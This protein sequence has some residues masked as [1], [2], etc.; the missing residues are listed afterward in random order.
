MS[1]QLSLLDAQSS[2]S[3][4]DDPPA[5]EAPFPRFT[6]P[7]RAPRRLLLLFGDQLDNRYLNAAGLDPKLDA[8][9]MMEV[10]EEAC[11]VPSHKARTTLFLS[12]MRHFA[13]RLV[14]D[15]APLI[16]RRLDETGPGGSFARELLCL[17]KCWKGEPESLV[18]VRPGEWRVLRDVEAVCE[19]LGWTF[20]MIEDDHFLSTPAQFSRWAKGRKQLVMEYFY[21]DLRR[22]LDVLMT[23]EKK[24]E[25]GQWNFDKDNRKPLKR[26][27]PPIPPPLRFPPDG[28]TRKVMA[29]VEQTFPDAPGRLSSFAWP[30][31][32][33]QVLTALQDFVDNRLPYFGDYQDAMKT[34]EPWLFHSLL[35]PAMNLKLLDP[36]EAVEAAVAAY[37]AGSAPLNAVEGFVRQIVGWREFIR[38]VYWHEGPGYSER[39]SLEATGD[40]PPMYWH[41]ETEMSC[42][43]DALDQVLEHGFGHHIQR[44]M[45][46]GNYALM[47]GVHPR[48]ISDWYLGM[49]VDAVDWVTLPNTLGMVMHADGGV[50]GTKPYAASGRYVQRMSDYCKS[51]RFDPTQRT[52]PEACPFTTFYWDFLDRQRDRLAG[53]RRMG[54]A[55]KNLDRLSD[56]E[57]AAIRHRA[58][59]L[60]DEA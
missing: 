52:G 40:L 4:G 39:N 19:E 51:C 41:G 16:Y 43:R 3:S 8:V 31:T 22:R 5:L 13:L 47:A 27:A 42:M 28:I 20:E 35:S 17:A 34:G 18:V 59:E 45:V 7:L 29:E 53:N 58:E 12:A 44:L 46:T 15:G 36:R 49:Y 6:V 1:Q 24:P 9:L 55:Y 26:G 23:A 33:E 30:V 50:V 14:E 11:H 37:R 48:A 54:F 60:R 2:D 21:R 56:T 32:R 57:L 38:G 25:G 10:S